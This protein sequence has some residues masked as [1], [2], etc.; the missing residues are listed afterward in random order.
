M[1]GM[2]AVGTNT[3]ASTSAIP[4]TGPESSGIG[5]LANDLNGAGLLVHLTVGEDDLAGMRVGAAVGESQLQ[6]DS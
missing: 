1:P 2:N 4:T 3:E 6:W 5:E